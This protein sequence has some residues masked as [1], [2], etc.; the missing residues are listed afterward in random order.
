MLERLLIPSLCALQ[1]I[2]ASNLHAGFHC[3]LGRLHIQN[4]VIIHILGKHEP[5]AP[6]QPCKELEIK[7]QRDTAFPGTPS[8]LGHSRYRNR[9]AQQRSGQ[10]QKRKTSKRTRAQGSLWTP[11]GHLPLSTTHRHAWSLRAVRC[12]CVSPHQILQDRT[13][14][15]ESLNPRCPLH[16]CWWRRHREDLHTGCPVPGRAER[17]GRGPLG[18]RVAF[19]GSGEHVRAP[20]ELARLK[21]AEVDPSCH[22]AISVYSR[23]PFQDAAIAPSWKP[24]FSLHTPTDSHFHTETV[25]AYTRV[26]WCVCLCC[27]WAC[28]EKNL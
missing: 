6:I 16:T 12:L 11:R 8:Q 17:A 24:S 4:E 28:W 21:R 22:L 3:D 14:P 19:C 25:Y 13:D 7:K 5:R 15:R 10:E 27:V 18:L 2:Q 23:C 9:Q 1:G 20:G 26:L